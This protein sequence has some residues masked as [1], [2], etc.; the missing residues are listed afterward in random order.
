M[1][2]KSFYFKDIDFTIKNIFHDIADEKQVHDYFDWHTLYY[3]K[4]K[5]INIKTDKIEFIN[6]NHKYYGNFEQKENAQFIQL[7]DLI[8]G[9]SNQILFETSKNRNKIKIASDFYPLF[10][11]LWNKPYNFNSSFNY[12][13]SQQVSIFPKTSIKSQIDFEGSYKDVN[14]FHNDLEITDPESLI[15]QSSLDNWF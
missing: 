11:R 6:S 5:R 15:E 9:C 13:R 3:L 7:I 2:A 12:V 4:N 14:Q 1:S 8:L 10:K